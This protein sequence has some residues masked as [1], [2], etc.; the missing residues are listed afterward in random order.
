MD[1]T[2]DRGETSSLLSISKQGSLMGNES[3][4]QQ[5]ATSPPY[6]SE[7]KQS[8]LFTAPGCPGIKGQVISE[9]SVSCSSS[10]KSLDF[11]V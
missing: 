9:L 10:H 5:A 8:S 2:L 11:A 3:C 1:A 6:Y 7:G 4:I